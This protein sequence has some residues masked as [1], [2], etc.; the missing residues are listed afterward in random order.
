MSNSRLLMV[1][2]WSPQV[3]TIVGFRTRFVKFGF[4][5]DL[6]DLRDLRGAPFVTFVLVVADNSRVSAAS[7][8]GVG[9]VCK[10]RASQRRTARVF[11]LGGGEFANVASNWD[12]KSKGLYK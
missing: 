6:R 11:H 8:V 10:R 9:I 5:R 12:T 7:P 2:M 3:P 4:L 1:V